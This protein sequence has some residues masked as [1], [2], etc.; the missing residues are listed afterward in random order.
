MPGS[1]RMY[2]E[3]D[4]SEIELNDNYLNKM[5]KE[6]PENYDKK[7]ERLKNE[8]TLEESKV[9]EMLKL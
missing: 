9:L 3:T 4:I 1:A 2:P 8:F 5:K 6:L 7:L